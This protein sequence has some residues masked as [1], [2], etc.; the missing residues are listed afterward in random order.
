MDKKEISKSPGKLGGSNDGI[1]VYCRLA[2]FDDQTI[3]LQKMNT[4]CLMM[5]FIQFD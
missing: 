5:Q 2:A 3:S 4:W 1:K